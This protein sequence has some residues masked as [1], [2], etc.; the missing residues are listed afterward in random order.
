LSHWPTDGKKYKHPVQ[1][2]A[3]AENRLRQRALPNFNEFLFLRFRAAN[4]PP[5]PFEWVDYQQT[6]KEYAALLVRVSRMYDDRF[7]N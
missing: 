7:G 5:Y 4:I 3:A 6:T 1:E 2:A